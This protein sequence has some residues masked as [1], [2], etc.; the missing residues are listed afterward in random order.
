MVGAAG[1]TDDLITERAECTDGTD[2]GAGIFTD[3]IAEADE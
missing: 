1:Y 3:D 2:N